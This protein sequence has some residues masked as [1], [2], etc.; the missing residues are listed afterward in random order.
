MKKLKIINS[1]IF[2]FYVLETIFAIGLAIM[3]YLGLS[4]TVNQEPG[5]NGSFAAALAMGVLAV[6]TIIFSAFALAKLIPAVLKL[7]DLIK[8]KRGLAIACMVFDTLFAALY[9]LAILETDDNSYYLVIPFLTISLISLLLNAISLSGRL[10][11]PLR[12]YVNPLQSGEENN[13]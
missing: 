1:I 10:R 13:G 9:T 7:I 3:S 6:L 8:N 11:N 4:S 12:Y 5:G 2:T